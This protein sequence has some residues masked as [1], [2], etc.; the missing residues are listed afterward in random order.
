ML[1]TISA[2]AFRHRETKKKPVSRWP[3]AGPSEYRLLASSPAS[4]SRKKKHEDL[5]TFTIM[6]RSIPLRMIS[7]TVKNCTENQNKHILCSGTFFKSFRLWNN[8]I[9]ILYI[10]NFCW[11]CI[12]GY[13]YQ[14]LTLSPLTCNIWWAPNNASRWHLTRRLKG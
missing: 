12:S 11:P 7:V 3:V 5:Q 4:K 2:F 13:L 6:S 1:G 14:W 10:S 9:K 8:V